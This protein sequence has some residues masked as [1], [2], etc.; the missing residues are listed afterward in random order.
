MIMG[1]RVFYHSDVFSPKR[2]IAMNGNL[3]QSNCKGIK[4]R[5]L[6]KEGFMCAVAAHLRVWFFPGFDL[7]ALF[8]HLTR[9][10]SPDSD[11]CLFHI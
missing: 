8:L 3:L 11:V 7:F 10:H 9:N 1:G 6:S 5:C 2:Q 4:L